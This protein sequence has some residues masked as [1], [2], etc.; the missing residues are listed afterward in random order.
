MRRTM[1]LATTALTLGFLALPLAACDTG[2]RTHLQKDTFETRERSTL[3]ESSYS[4]ETPTALLDKQALQDI[5]ENYR[6][7][8]E[9]PVSVLVSYDPS[10]H[11]NTASHATMEAKRIARILMDTGVPE[12][13]TDIL[14]ANGKGQ[15][16]T[17][18]I[19]YKTVVAQA[20]EDCQ[21]MGGLDGK[22]TDANPD[23]PIG[24]TM[25]MQM[26]QQIA[27]PQDMQGRDGLDGGSA[28]RQNNIVDTYKQGKPNPPLS[29]VQSVAGQ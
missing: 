29:G 3:R 9:G 16:S 7:Y 14:P 11:T 21:S 26:D 13:K 2:Y 1:R 15:P 20:P 17:T 12:V 27:R 10:A 19:S 28:R 8:G 6:Q 5:G 4:S 23:Y 24:C 18:V 25:Q 22:Q